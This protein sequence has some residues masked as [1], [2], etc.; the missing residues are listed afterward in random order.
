M[1]M[2]HGVREISQYIEFIYRVTE[3]DLYN[4]RTSL[5]MNKLKLLS[6]KIV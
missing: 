2:F 6:L 5:S 1:L 3:A 4:Y